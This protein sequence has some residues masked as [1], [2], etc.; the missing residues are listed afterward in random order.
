M[1]PPR[2]LMGKLFEGIANRKNSKQANH[3]KRSD[4]KGL[5]I[6]INN[7]G[8]STLTQSAEGSLR[9]SSVEL[10]GDVD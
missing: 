10:A 2:Y 8:I 9:S 3:E 5:V 7:G 6:N 1:E 4:I